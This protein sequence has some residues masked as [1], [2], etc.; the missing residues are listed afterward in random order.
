RPLPEY[1]QATYGEGWVEKQAPPPGALPG[2]PLPAFA[3][4]PDAP[5]EVRLAA[6]LDRVAQPHTDAWLNRIRTLVEGASTYEE[7]AAGLL[8]LYP[9][10]ALGGLAEAMQQALAVANL[11]GRA[12]LGDSLV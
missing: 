12:E 9:Q 7:I 4:G 1:I 11:T 3:E 5:P 2:M 8:A 10:L 6:Q